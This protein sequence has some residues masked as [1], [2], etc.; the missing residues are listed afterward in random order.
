MT[1]HSSVILSAS[2]NLLHRDFCNAL[3]DQ[4]ESLAQR[5]GYFVLSS[6][7]QFGFSVG[8]G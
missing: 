6:T 2:K 4:N 3:A 7:K 1:A 5:L 8:F